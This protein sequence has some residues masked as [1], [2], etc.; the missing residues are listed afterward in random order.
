MTDP[1]KREVD[2]VNRRRMLAALASSGVLAAAGCSGDGDGGTSTGGGDGDGDG[3]GGTETTE[4]ETPATEG[5]TPTPVPEE[6]QDPEFNWAFKSD[7][8]PVEANL[9]PEAASANNP[10]FIQN[11]WGAMG[12]QANL[13][14]EPIYL[15]A[16]SFEVADDNKSATMTYREGLEWWDGTPLRGKDVVAS[17]KIFNFQT[18]YQ[19]ESPNQPAEIVSDDPPTIRYNYDCAQNPT[20]ALLNQRFGNSWPQWEWYEPWLNEYR[21]ASSESEINSVT[22]EFQQAEITMQ[23]VVDNEYGIGLW[24]PSDWN[25]QKLVHEKW[26]GHRWSDRTN[27]EKFTIDL[28]ESNQKLTQAVSNGRVDAGSVGQISGTGISNDAYEVVHKVPTGAQIGLKLN[29][30]NKHLNRPR[31][32]RALAY[33]INHNEILQALKSGIGVNATS[34][35]TQN[36]ATTQIENNFLSESVRN[37]MINYGQ[38]AQLDEAT[39]MMEDAGYSKQGGNWVGPDGDTIELTH[40]TPSWNKYKFISNYLSDKL[41][42]FG[43]QTEVQPLSYS[44]FQNIWQNSF[45]YDMATWFQ[46]GLHP[47]LWYGLGRNGKGWQELNG[48]GLSMLANPDRDVG[49]DPVEREIQEGKKRDDRLNQVIRPE[50]PGQ[51]GTETLDIDDVGN[52]KTL[53]PFVLNQQMRQATSK[54]RLVELTKEFAW[55]ANWAV[56]NLEL[57]D[58]VFTNFGKTDAFQFPD[59][60]QRVYYHRAPWLWMKEGR[61][62]GR[63]E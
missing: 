46:Q 2:S 19:E 29:K 23:D 16:E 61:V 21:N 50:Y 36:M 57:F 40:I 10:W 55:Y 5:P 15:N 11:I 17:N 54:E 47:A 43:V 49:C 32:R 4:M 51:V 35:G 28:L 53:K 1:D 7:W 45:E 25:T 31:V 38:G 52:V 14:G 44:G 60:S 48:W 6:A 63:A 39:T 22:E 59:R 37:N 3:D 9:N 13:R 58:E 12:V 20:L 18:Y 27:L 34:P 41:G 24:K 56:P 30:A 33:A 62:N 26:E 42:N 8:N